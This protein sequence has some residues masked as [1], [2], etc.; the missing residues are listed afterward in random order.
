MTLHDSSARDRPF[1]GAHPQVAGAYVESPERLA[2]AGPPLEVA[3]APSGQGWVI[4][5]P[6]RAERVTLSKQVVVRERVVIRQREVREIAQLDATVRR[7]QLRVETEG[8]AKVAEQPRT[9]R[10]RRRKHRRR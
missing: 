5:I 2:T 10:K 8:Q 9:R 6:V 4:R 3:R 1:P 7:E